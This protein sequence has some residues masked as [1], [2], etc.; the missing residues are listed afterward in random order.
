[1]WSPLGS[2]GAL[3]LSAGDSFS[4]AA[5]S[6][7]GSTTLAAGTASP[8][9]AH[10]YIQIFGT[11]VTGGSGDIDIVSTG[12][13]L[14]QAPLHVFG[15]STLG[16]TQAAAL[17]V[18]GSSTLG[19]T[20]AASLQVSGSASLGSTQT[21][22]LQVLGSSILGNTQAASLQVP[23]SSTL[24]STA[25]NS[26]QVKAA[27]QFDS[28]AVVEGSLWVSGDISL[29]DNSTSSLSVYAVTTFESTASPITSNAAIIANAAVTANAALTVTGPFQVQ[30][31]AVIGTSPSN[32]LTLNAVATF[33][34]GKT[35]LYSNAAVTSSSAVLAFQRRLA[36]AAVA[37]GTVLGQIQFTGW[38][39]VVYGL[40]AQLRSV[41]TVSM[42]RASQHESVREANTDC[43]LLSKEDHGA[44]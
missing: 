23:G 27:A 43:S 25:V 17:Q 38:D 32:T 2:A 5:N 29:G 6:V 14:V 4:T 19:S 31:A 39:G 24:G 41:F 3:L 15:I 36:T 7:G 34:A 20:Q 40:G 1:M 8:D 28:D 22:S 44:F 37:T 11:S 13:V 21:A 26:L 18:T 30:G 42:C 16:S 10:S 9:S 33:T 12:S 35:L